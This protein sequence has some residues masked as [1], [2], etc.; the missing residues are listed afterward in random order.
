MRPPATAVTCSSAPKLSTL[1]PLLVMLTGIEKCFM[2]IV[3]AVKVIIEY[4]IVYEEFAGVSIQLGVAYR[5]LTAAGGGASSIYKCS[6]AYNL[7]IFN[8][9]DG[10]QFGEYYF[11]LFK[12]EVSLLTLKH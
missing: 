5:K 11:G 2:Y 1:A 4:I 9:F 8:L 12:F 7:G 6:E 3:V 10:V